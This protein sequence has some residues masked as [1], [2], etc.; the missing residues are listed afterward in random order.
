LR[1]QPGAQESGATGAAD[2]VID[3]DARL[4][5]FREALV[6]DSLLAITWLS[7]CIL[8]LSAWRNFLGPESLR[9]PLAFAVVAVATAIVTTTC[10]FRS[11]LGYPVKSNALLSMLFL[12]GLGGLLSFG[13]AAPTG[14]YFAIAFFIAAI[15]YQRTTVFAMIAGT[16]AL[17]ALV[18]YAVISGYQAITVNLNEVARQPTAWVN[19]M[20]TMGLTA[21]AIATAAGAFTRSVYGLLGDLHRQQLE[22]A[23]QRD[24]IQHL[25]T[26]DKLTGL[27]ML[28][29]AEDRSEV[30]IA[31]AERFSCKLAF[32][33]VD[34]DGFK[35]INDRHGHDAG[36]AVLK[37][38][39]LRL[40][41]SLRSA[42]TAARIGGDEFLIIL[43]DLGEARFAGEVAQK[44][45]HAIAA[46]IAYGTGQLKIGAS[47]GIAVFPDHARDLVELK[48]AAD[49]AMYAV[50]AAGKNSF[51]FAADPSVDESTR[52]ASAM[53]M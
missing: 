47:I 34:L 10:M 2:G 31:H 17:L 46:P 51:R 40:K 38:V 5:Q 4:Q 29:L 16:L 50:K 36:D 53:V 13:N 25:A 19:L 26:H 23:R 27:P 1:A 37:E 22:I 11:R 52:A 42:D 21:G 20:M 6:D 49:K 48:R 43:N 41:T 28:R 9:W 39:A 30:A 44:I 3:P 35:E 7:L 32:M 12:A 24:Q 15:L 8:A 18:A 45:L 33:F 14:S